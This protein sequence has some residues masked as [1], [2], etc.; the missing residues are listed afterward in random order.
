MTIGYFLC[1]AF[2]GVSKTV[3]E[4]ILPILIMSIISFITKVV[5]SISSDIFTFI[6]L[7]S[8]L[9]LVKLF[10]REITWMLSALGT[11]LTLITIVF[12]V[13]MWPFMNYLAGAGP[14]EIKP[15][16]WEWIYFSLVEDLIPLIVLIL[17]K[18]K[19]ISL[20]KLLAK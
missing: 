9:V 6:L 14:I 12:G 17:L 3:K 5:F 20:M 1:L 7:F 8:W 11:F 2:I 16:T 10:N 18:V 13:M 19:K 4:V 15:N